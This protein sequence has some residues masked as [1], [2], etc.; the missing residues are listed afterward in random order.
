MSLSNEEQEKI[1]DRM[2]FSL[3][4]MKRLSNVGMSTKNAMFFAGWVSLHP[5]EK[6]MIYQDS[7]DK[8]IVNIDI[9]KINNAAEIPESN[10]FSSE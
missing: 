7:V 5:Y 9:G 8:D 1:D 10:Q 4:A 3:Y 6:Q 2:R